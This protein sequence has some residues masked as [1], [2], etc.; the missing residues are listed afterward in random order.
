MRIAR[1]K[2][3]NLKKQFGYPAKRGPLS[4]GFTLIELLVVVLIIGILSS[5]A[6]PQYNRAVHKARLAENLVRGKALRDIVDVYILENGFISTG[7]SIDLTEI[8]PDSVAGLT[9]ESDGKWHSKTGIFFASC[10][11]T[12][13]CGAEYS[14]KSGD[15]SIRLISARYKG[16]TGWSHQCYY[17]GS[18]RVGK[19]LCES[20]RANGYE[21]T[22]LDNV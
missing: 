1:R 6:L 19:F 22:D 9:K 7:P 3:M 4:A 20:L 14:Y 12:E 2:N 21:L 5:V 11:S 18:D 8:Y 17:R 10:T 16:N 15:V 13:D